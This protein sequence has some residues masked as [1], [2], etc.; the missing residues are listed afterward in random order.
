MKILTLTI[1][2]LLTLMVTI[3]IVPDIKNSTSNVD[4]N[5]EDATIN[6]RLTV[7]MQ[8]P[9][10]EVRGS[11]VRAV[12]LPN[13]RPLLDLPEAGSG[14]DVVG[15]AAIIDLG[16]KGKVFALISDS[17]WRELRY[18]FDYSPSLK[19][20]I[21]ER[22]KMK[23]EYYNNLPKHQKKT[24]ELHNRPQM[25]WFE[26]ISDPKSVKL[27][28]QSITTK[29]N[30]TEWIEDDHSAE[31]FGGDYAVKSMTVEITDEPVTWGVVE[32]LLPWIWEYKNKLFDGREIHTIK[33]EY[34]L[35]NSL[36]AGSFA[37]KETR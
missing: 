4:I 6:Y 3:F 1:I 16:E 32:K 10:G 23:I 31:L 5:S 34:P 14:I 17:S 12:K 9:E 30:G 18:T 27:V 35:A 2:A 36:G 11:T 22:N 15:E 26:N 7:T 25:V 28:Y 21:A 13:G 19:Y 8:T 29:P 20:S 33:S 37:I 24:L